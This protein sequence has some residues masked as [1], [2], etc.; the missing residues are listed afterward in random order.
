MHRFRGIQKRREFFRV[1]GE[2]KKS[3]VA[4]MV[5]K[6]GQISGTYGNEHPRADQILYVI[7]GTGKALVGGRT[8]KLRAGDALVI[9]AGERHQITNVGRRPL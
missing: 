1:L 6:P 4:T 7:E 8:M 9:E 3:Q 2:T 5:L